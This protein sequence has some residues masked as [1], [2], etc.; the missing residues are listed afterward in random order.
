M[1]KVFFISFLI[2]SWLGITVYSGCKTSEEEEQIYDIRGT[3][4]LTDLNSGSSKTIT[5]SGS[6][7]N[8]NFICGIGSGVYQVNGTSVEW[9]YP[10]DEVVYRGDFVNPNRMEGNYQLYSK[11]D[12]YPWVA[13][14]I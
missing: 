12:L 13:N 9:H 7:T 6:L 1:K 11:P 8:G 14:R 4:T 10:G 5:F 2:I 3:W